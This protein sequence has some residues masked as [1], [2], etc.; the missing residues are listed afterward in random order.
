MKG[1]ANQEE[2]IEYLFTYAIKQITEDSIY[3][4]LSSVTVA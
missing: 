1:L 3:N 4:I 2:K